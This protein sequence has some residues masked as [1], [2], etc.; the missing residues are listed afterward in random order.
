MVKVNGRKH[1]ESA[2]VPELALATERCPVAHPASAA[3][4]TMA[5]GV[6]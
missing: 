3:P 1:R 6:T 5:L 4:H 2:R